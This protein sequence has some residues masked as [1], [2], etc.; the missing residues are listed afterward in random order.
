MQGFF[1]GSSLFNICI[2]LT[3]ILA[4]LWFRVCE[5]FFSVLFCYAVCSIFLYQRPTKY[6]KKEF[7]T[8]KYIMEPI[9]LYWK[10]SP[11][12]RIKVRWF[13]F[14]FVSQF[15]IHIYVYI[16]F[17]RTRKKNSNNIKQQQRIPNIAS[18]NRTAFDLCAYIM[19]MQ[20]ICSFNIEWI[21]CEDKHQY[22]YIY[23]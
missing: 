18:F 5:C 14:F 9:L 2:A 16:Q 12:F 22:I 17:E 1:L 6:T 10:C 21:H 3:L 11:L 13:F 20:T 23:K 4:L 15:F 7:C 19:G 8:H